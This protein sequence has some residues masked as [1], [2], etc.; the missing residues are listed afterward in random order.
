MFTVGRTEEGS[1]KVP[2]RT[3]VNCGRADELADSW[4]PQLG[5]KRCR[6]S[7]PLLAVLVNSLS[8]PEISSAAVGTSILTVPLADMCWQSRH[9]QILIASGSAERR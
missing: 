9:Q 1:S 8:C 3:T 6:I 4:Q 2:A 7:F 5:Q